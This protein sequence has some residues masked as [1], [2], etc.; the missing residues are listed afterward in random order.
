MLK[1]FAPLFHLFGT[2][3]LNYHGKQYFIFV[4]FQGIHCFVLAFLLITD[5]PQD[6]PQ[7]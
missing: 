2:K 1:V 3:D 4:G 5:E 7:I 6:E